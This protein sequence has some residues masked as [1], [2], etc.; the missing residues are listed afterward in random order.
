[1]PRIFGIRRAMTARRISARGIFFAHASGKRSISSRTL[2]G[3]APRLLSA[4]FKKVGLSVTAIVWGWPLEESTT[5]V[6]GRC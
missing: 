2:V 3:V 6:A 5:L 1:M 4:V